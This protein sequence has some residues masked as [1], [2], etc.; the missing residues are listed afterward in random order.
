MNNFW[1][2]FEKR[3]S[4]AAFDRSGR[5]LSAIEEETRKYEQSGERKKP[6]DLGEINYTKSKEV[7]GG[8]AGDLI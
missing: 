2:G 7:A 6:H 5:E 3:A 8:S 4:E 1:N